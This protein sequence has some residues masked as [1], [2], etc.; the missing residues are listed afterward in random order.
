MFRTK[1]PLH[2]R[3]EEE[4]YY[5]KCFGLKSD[6]TGITNFMGTFFHASVNLKDAHLTASFESAQPTEH[7]RSCDLFQCIK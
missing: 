6:Y 7:F 2:K 3:R 4:M 5:W 1:F